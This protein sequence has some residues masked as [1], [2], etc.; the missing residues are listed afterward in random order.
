MSGQFGEVVGE[1]S[2]EGLMI[3]SRLRRETRVLHAQLERAVDLPSR[4][5]SK[6]SYR[7]LLERF[8]G[9]YTPLEERLRR[10]AG[11]TAFAD[12]TR[13]GKAGLLTEDPL[14]L[15]ATKDEIAALRRCA[16]LPVVESTPALFGSLYVV[17]GATLGGQVV[18]R[19][20][21]RLLPA[22]SLSSSRFFHSYGDRV[23]VMWT[24]FTSALIDFSS[25]TPGQGTAVVASAVTTFSCFLEWVTC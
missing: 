8:W 13:F 14:S 7:A 19:Q 16:H 9:F 11:N 18:G 22:A 24:A 5:E 1:M 10:A 20:L 23:G 6:D 4:L 12:G 21:E 15:G 17:E 3:L 25:A 2:G